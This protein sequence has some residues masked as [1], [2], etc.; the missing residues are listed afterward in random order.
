[1]KGNRSQGHLPLIGVGPLIVVP[2]ILATALGIAVSQSGAVDIARTPLLQIPFCIAGFLLIAFAVYLWVRANFGSRIDDR[3]RHNELVTD[4]VY[5]IVRNP[6]YSAF[7]LA[8][9]G[10]ILFADNLLL[11]VLPALFWAYMTLALRTTEEKCLS[12]LY[13]EEYREYCR[14]VNRCIPSLCHCC[15][16]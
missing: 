10:A 9:T 8:C 14:H 11:L 5:G 13:G 6:I 7:F 16:S 15:R 3:I 2:Q 12:N 1:M 4:G